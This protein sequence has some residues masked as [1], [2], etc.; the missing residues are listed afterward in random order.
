MANCVTVIDLICL[1]EVVEIDKVFFSSSFRFRNLRLGLDPNPPGQVVTVE[2]VLPVTRRLVRVAVPL[3]A[4]VDTSLRG[5]QGNWRTDLSVS[6]SSPKPLLLTSTMAELA[7]CLK[8]SFEGG[9]NTTSKF[10][11]D[12]KSALPEFKVDFL[13]REFWK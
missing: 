4:V 12:L 7:R 5:M 9:S 1:S 6:P 8:N 13:K 10:A 3:I 2:G 11:D